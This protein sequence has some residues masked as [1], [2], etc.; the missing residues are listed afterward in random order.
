MASAANGSA[1]EN[2]DDAMK[3]MR[4]TE[5]ENEYLRRGAKCMKRRLHRSEAPAVMGKES[6]GRSGC[7]HH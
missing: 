4:H 3:K 1:V 6:L 5:I 7:V 2:M